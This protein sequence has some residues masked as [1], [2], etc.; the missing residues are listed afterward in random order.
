VL[1]DS[2]ILARETLRSP[3]ASLKLMARPGIEPGRTIQSYRRLTTRRAWGVRLPQLHRTQHDRV[4]GQSPLG[5][6]LQAPP[7]PPWSTFCR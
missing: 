3:V 2:T 7:R 6:S 4:A 1:S 5:M